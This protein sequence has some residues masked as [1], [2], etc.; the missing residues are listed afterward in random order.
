MPASFPR[1]SLPNDSGRS[2]SR[3]SQGILAP[4]SL[5]K[6]GAC[7]VL[8]GAHRELSHLVELPLEVDPAA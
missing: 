3:R 1:K 4:T 6:A 5:P 7:Q 2:R 8:A